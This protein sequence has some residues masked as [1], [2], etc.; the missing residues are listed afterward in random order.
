MST[1]KILNKDVSNVVEESLTGYL[2]AY[3]KYYKKIGEYNAFQYRGHRKDKVALVIGGGS[4]HEPL[5]TGYCGA[6]LAD[7]V[8]CGN[9]CASPNPELIMMAAK[10]VDQGKGVLFV[11]GNYAGDNLNFDMAEEM[12]R[13]EGMK[14]AH[15]R[16]WDD[17]A[18]APKERITDRRGIAGDVYTIKI[19]GAA[20]DAGLDLDEVVRITE[21]ARDNTNTIGLATSPGTLPGNDKPT[22]EIADD[23][24]EFGMGLHGE[25]GIE[26][27]K[28][29]PCCDM[30]ERMY[31]ELMAEMGLKSGDEIAV[32]VNG[33]GST[34]LLE[35]NLVYYELYKCMHRDGLKVYDAEVK[36]Y[37]TCMEMGGFSIT[38]L[39]LDDELK[40]YYDAPCY[41]PYYAKGSF[42]GVV[43]DA[44]SDAD[45]EEPEFDETDVEPAVITRSKDGVLEELNAEDT[46]NML[47]YIADKIIANKPYLTEVD[48]A[49]GDGDHGIGM[50]G[51]MQKAKKKLLKMQGEEN[52]YHL[53]ETAGQAMLMSMGG[54]SGVIFGSLYLAG[55]KGM[56]PK[57]TITAEDL[58]RMEKKSLDAIQERGGAQVGDKTMVDALAPAV[59]A[60]EANSGKGLLEMLKAAEEAARCGMEDTKKYVAKF[61]RAKSL[62]ERA[63]G[64]Q[65]AGATSVYLIFQ[66]MREFVEGAID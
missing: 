58:A 25:P 48:S 30:V 6:G 60:L 26:R 36:T 66:G 45:E 22:F 16:E 51:G 21:K 15:V 8:A 56:D 28:M 10:A 1:K 24:M 47:L 61:G 38:F 5:F 31:N 49:I 37:C 55:A 20:C 64:H 3:K 44:S 9:I 33:L 50:A 63:I 65:D 40:K 52:A 35:L 32:L 19:A 2:M 42:S 46:R 59:D 43:E 12:C 17:F 34:P 27:T 7:A 23:E 54:A 11:Y 14:T 62:L 53:F 39:K 4:G 13:A 41:S 18:S 29:M 57:G